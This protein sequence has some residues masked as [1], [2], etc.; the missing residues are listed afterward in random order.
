M[1]GGGGQWWPQSLHRKKTN[2]SGARS[3]EEADGTQGQ[4]RITCSQGYMH[5]EYSQPVCYELGFAGERRE[6]AR[7]LRG[8][9]AV[10]AEAAE[11]RGK[12]P[13]LSSGQSEGQEISHL[14]EKLLV[15]S[16]CHP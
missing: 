11:C 15:K 9:V 6:A 13:C 10:T 4:A 12:G 14:F 16:V 2:L 8:G 3:L 1:G 5:T 7:T